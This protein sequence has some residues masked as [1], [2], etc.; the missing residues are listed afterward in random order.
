MKNT[1]YWMDNRLVLALR[2]SGGHWTG[3]E[4]ARASFYFFLNIFCLLF[5]AK[6]SG[7]VP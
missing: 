5:P 7:F 2:G 6:M 4:K 1:N 3:K